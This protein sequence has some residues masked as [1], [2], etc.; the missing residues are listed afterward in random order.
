MSKETARAGMNNE[1]QEASDAGRNETGPKR[2]P[3]PR[4]DSTDLQGTIIITA[5]RDDCVHDVLQYPA[6]CGQLSPRT[7]MQAIG[8]RLFLHAQI[9]ISRYLCLYKLLHSNP[10]IEQ[11]I[12][13][14]KEDM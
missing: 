2:A 4:G 7:R 8:R 12:T 6:A 10:C 11:I 1:R 5:V 14:A 9:V 3:R 13:S